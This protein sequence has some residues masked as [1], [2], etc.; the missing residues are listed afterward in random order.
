[1]RRKKTSLP[2]IRKG[3]K[4]KE[5]YFAE[6]A[7][8]DDD[9]EGAVGLIKTDKKVI[10][11]EKSLP[12]TSNGSK[13]LTLNHELAHARLSKVNLE[14]IIGHE[15]NEKFVELEAIVRTPNRYLTEAEAVLRHF[16]LGHGTLSIKSDFDKIVYN[17][18]FVMDL[19]Y[20]KAL[21]KE[22]V[23]G[24]PREAKK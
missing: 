13:R 3:Y 12:V 16:L 21:F 24:V 22:L 1:M 6:R 15:K 8:A 5:A 20:N 11:I 14:K 9:F 19:K 18:L 23:T 7:K 4:I 2:E 10:Y 17:I